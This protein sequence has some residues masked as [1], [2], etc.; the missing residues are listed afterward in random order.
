MTFQ[1]LFIMMA[2]PHPPATTPF[3]HAWTNVYIFFYFVKNVKK[4]FYK[5]FFDLFEYK[6]ICQGV[7]Q[8]LCRSSFSNF[9]GKKTRLGV[10]YFRIFQL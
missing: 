6:V 4:T 3:P 5:F 1:L 10:S 8:N 7:Y 9:L 2:V